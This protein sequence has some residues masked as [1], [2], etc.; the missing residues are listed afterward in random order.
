VPSV[1]E[2]MLVGE[3]WQYP[4][5]TFVGELRHPSTALADEV[6]V[7]RLCGYRLIALEPLAE[8]VCPHQTTLYQKIEGAIDR[9]QPDLLALQL[10]LAA[11]PLDREMILR[12]KHHLGNEITLASDRLMVLV[13]MP[14]ETLE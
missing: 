14:A 11:N 10:E 3:D 6:L 9:G 7:I 5:E 13:E 8:L 1:L 4:L 12:E 2:A